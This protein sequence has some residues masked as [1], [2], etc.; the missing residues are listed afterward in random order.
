[1][2]IKELLIKLIS[3]NL[4]HGIVDHTLVEKMD[5]YLLV[6]RITEEDYKEMYAMMFP[7]Q[8][9]VVGEE[10]VV[11]EEIIDEDMMVEVEDMPTIIPEIEDEPT[12]IPEV[13]V[14]TPT[15]IPDF[16]EVSTFKPKAKKSKA[17]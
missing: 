8:E 13:E 3:H 6:G 1:M 14:D 17:K 10:V 9:E 11:E 16:S 12:I 5:L 4:A 15:I 2:Q 7:Q